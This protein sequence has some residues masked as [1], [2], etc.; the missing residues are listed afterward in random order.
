VAELLADPGRETFFCMT[1]GQVNRLLRPEPL[2]RGG[3]SA[4]R[5][6]F[7]LDI[8][9]RRSLFEASLSFLNAH[10]AHKRQKSCFISY[11]WGDADDERWVAELASD[12]GKAG[13]DVILD[14]KDNSRVGSSVARFIERIQNVDFVAVVGTPA[15]KTKYENPDGSV[16]AAEGDLINQRL[17]GSELLKKT[18]FPLLRAGERSDAFPVLVATRVSIDFRDPLQYFAN[19]VDLIVD[20]HDVPR[21]LPQVAEVREKLSPKRR[22]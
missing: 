11:A 8:A 17:L 21:D 20:L 10:A 7:E 14:R 13:I 12:L 15:Y 22:A 4:E 5:P 6:S 1:C 2:L 3:A 18:V 16:V 19:L 9:T